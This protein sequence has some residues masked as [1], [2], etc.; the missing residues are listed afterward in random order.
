MDE[1]SELEWLTVGE[2]PA[3]RGVLA[4]LPR[5]IVG[6]TRESLEAT[7]WQMAAGKL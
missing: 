7:A 3:F 1:L 5:L 2:K 4:G 6:E